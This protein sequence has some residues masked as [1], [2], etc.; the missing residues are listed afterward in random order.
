MSIAYILLFHPPEK[1]IESITEKTVQTS[2]PLKFKIT[3]MWLSFLLW[4]CILQQS[5]STDALFLEFSV[6]YIHR[7]YVLHILCY[8]GHFA[9]TFH[10][11]DSPVSVTSEMQLSIP[12][13]KT[14]S[15]KEVAHPIL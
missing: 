12:W 10:A 7:H 3:P 11:Q 2:K 8:S 5:L 1:Q 13:K 9:W 6:N 4:I 15:I 14:C